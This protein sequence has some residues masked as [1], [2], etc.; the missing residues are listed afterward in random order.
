MGVDT[1]L[2]QDGLGK[3]TANGSFFV[4]KSNFEGT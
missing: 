3:K 4:M 2:M 1:R